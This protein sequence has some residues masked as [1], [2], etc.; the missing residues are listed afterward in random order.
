[1]PRRNQNRHKIETPTGRPWSGRTAAAFPPPGTLVD[2]LRRASQYTHAYVGS[3]TGVLVLKRGNQHRGI[4]L[5]R[6]WPGSARTRQGHHVVGRGA[7]LGYRSHVSGPGV[8]RGAFFRRPIVALIPPSDPAAGSTD[9]VQYRFRHFEP[10]T[11][12]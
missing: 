6:C 5:F 8:E 11:K 3:H 4:P 1:P 12:P 7:P 9:V 2:R 10:H